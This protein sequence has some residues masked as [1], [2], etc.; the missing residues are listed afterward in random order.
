[1]KRVSLTVMVLGHE[2]VGKTS[3][4][5]VLCGDKYEPIYKNTTVL[6]VYDKETLINE[7]LVKFEF[8]DLSGAYSFPAMRKLY[9]EKADIFFLVYD[10]TCESLDEI[11]RLKSEIESVRK[12]HISE[13]PV[14]VIKAK[15]DSSRSRKIQSETEKNISHWCRNVFCCSAKRGTN[16]AEIEEFLLS[17]GSFA[18]HTKTSCQ[19]RERTSSHRLSGRYIYTGRQRAKS[20]VLNRGHR[21]RPNSSC[22]S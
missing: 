1:M 14:A 15:C 3:V 13:L 7:L 8:L 16:I 11:I 2:S 5:K 12:T 19:I 6:D 4:I 10:R 20:M 17:E 18:D 9:I 22:C 21:N